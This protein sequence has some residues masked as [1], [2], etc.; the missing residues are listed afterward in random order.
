M[1][2]QCGRKKSAKIDHIS[3]STMKDGR[4]D[5]TQSTKESLSET[6][7][8]DS[9]ARKR[10]IKRLARRSFE[11][12]SFSR[13][14]RECKNLLNELALQIRLKAP[15]DKE[16]EDYKTFTAINLTMGDSDFEK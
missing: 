16:R 3:L 11:S 8:E 9:F 2:S 5:E 6:K 13:S 7:E 10:P 15:V 4:I 12:S 14:Y 1:L